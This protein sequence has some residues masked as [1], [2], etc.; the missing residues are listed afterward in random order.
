MAK[1]ITITTAKARAKAMAKTTVII[2][3][4][5]PGRKLCQPRPMPSL[6]PFLLTSHFQVSLKS[7]ED[8]CHHT[9]LKNFWVNPESTE[10][11]KGLI[12]FGLDFWMVKNEF[13]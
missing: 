6:R 2:I 4:K 1:A 5:G 12:C 8:G 9:P 11:S 10:E 3:V 7:S 13:L